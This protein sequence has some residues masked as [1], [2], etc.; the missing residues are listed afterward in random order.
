MPRTLRAERRRKMKFLIIST[1]KD[2]MSM[3]PPAVARQIM[4]ASIAQMDELKKAGKILEMYAI[5]GEG[6]AAICE[7]PS[8]EDLAQTLEAIPM[9]RF[10]N[11]KVYPLADFSEVMKTSLESV[12]RAEQLFPSAQK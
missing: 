3:V 11:M 4:E 6:G 12:K 9:L 8:A 5:P 2:T 7:H 1:M 10:M